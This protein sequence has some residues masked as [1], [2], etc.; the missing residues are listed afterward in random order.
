MGARP[1]VPR[2]CIRVKKELERVAARRDFDV[3]LRPKAS[4]YRIGDLTETPIQP[5][6]T[7]YVAEPLRPGAAAQIVTLLT[8]LG[9]SP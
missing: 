9:V 6:M 2:R 3:I 4:K 7:G 1:H 5:V 8:N